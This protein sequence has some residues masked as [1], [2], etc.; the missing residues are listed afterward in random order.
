MIDSVYCEFIKQER[1][2]ITDFNYI[3][4]IEVGNHNGEPQ[5]T[6]NTGKF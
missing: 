3:F 5:S 1:N 6:V 2:Q 4:S